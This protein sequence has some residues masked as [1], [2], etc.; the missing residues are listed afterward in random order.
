[1][2]LKDDVAAKEISTVSGLSSKSITGL[3]AYRVGSVNVLE[4]KHS[5]GTVFLKSYLGRWE[6]GGDVNWG[7]GT[8]VPIP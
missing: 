3:T 6:Y 5:T 8:E 1:M 2:S 4:V 7:S